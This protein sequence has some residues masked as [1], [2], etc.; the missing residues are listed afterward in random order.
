VSTTHFQVRCLVNRAALLRTPGHTHEAGKSKATMSDLISALILDPGCAAAVFNLTI[1]LWKSGQKVLACEKWLVFLEVPLDRAP[2]YYLS[3]STSPPAL[4][5]P[6]APDA[7]PSG[8]A[9]AVS[10][11]ILRC[12]YGSHH[13]SLSPCILVFLLLRRLFPAFFLPTLTFIF[14]LQLLL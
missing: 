3:L 2:P 6:T 4:L 7:P 10:V 14:Y 8:M 1:E 13:F 9:N 12:G 11:E 5:Q